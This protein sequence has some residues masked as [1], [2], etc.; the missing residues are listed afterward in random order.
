MGS[1]RRRIV[2]IL[3]GAAVAIAGG[4][5][6]WGLVTTANMVALADEFSP[7]PGSAKTGE[8][9]T[10]PTPLCWGGS[11][12]PSVFRSWDSSEAVDNSVL[13][14]LIK[15]SGWN[16]RQ[17]GDCGPG[18]EVRTSGLVCS[19]SGLVDGFLA[20][21]HVVA[22]RTGQSKGTLSLDLSSVVP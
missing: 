8:R 3:V 22:P 6:A 16:L 12:C 15:Q 1:Q 17:E 19:A 9:V 20:T 13:A 2:W 11:P 21:V 10:Q 4:S 18:D 5:V 7:P 14:D